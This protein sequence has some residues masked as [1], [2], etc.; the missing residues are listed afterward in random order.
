M[1]GPL[2]FRCCRSLLAFLLFFLGIN[3]CSE[4]NVGSSAGGVQEI[5]SPDRSGADLG[6]PVPADPFLSDCEPPLVHDPVAGYCVPR[7]GEGLSPQD[8]NFRTRH[9]WLQEAQSEG[10]VIRY[11]IPGINPL[12]ELLETNVSSNSS[13]SFKRLHNSYL[14]K[15]I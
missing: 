6:G 14:E 7:L 11:I 4:S 9:R 13:S 2:E 12:N 5:E 10:E 8:G 1:G 15:R 3:G